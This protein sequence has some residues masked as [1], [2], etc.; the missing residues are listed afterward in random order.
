M[1]HVRVPHLPRPCF[2]NDRRP[3]F[4]DGIDDSDCLECWVATFP[5]TPRALVRMWMGDAV[6]R[7]LITEGR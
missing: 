2:A 1:R 4:C 7:R 6:E 5:E 3:E